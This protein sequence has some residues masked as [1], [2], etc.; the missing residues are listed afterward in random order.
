MTSKAVINN[1]AGG[2]IYR[3]PVVVDVMHLGEAVVVGNN[4]SEAAINHGFL[5]VNEP[6]RKVSGSLGDGGRVD[7]EIEFASAVRDP[8]GSCTNGI[9]RF[10]LSGDAANCVRAASGNG[11]TD[12]AL[13]TNSRDPSQ[14]YIFI[15]R[16]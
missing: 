11:I 2:V 8:L 7:V 16:I 14:Y 13:K 6:F 15:I 9:V 5:H 1:K 3:V 4:I 10:D 12:A